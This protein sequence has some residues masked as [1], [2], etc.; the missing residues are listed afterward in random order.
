MTFP[1]HQLKFVVEQPEDLAEI[2]VLLTRIDSYNT[3]DVLL[4]PQAVTPEEMIERGHW[5]ADI[6]KQRGFRYCPR[7]HIS[8]YGNVRGK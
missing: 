4:M 6:C 5:I 3:S 7:L 2:D 8:L 1:D